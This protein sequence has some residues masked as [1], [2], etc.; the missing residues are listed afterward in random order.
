MALFARKGE[1]LLYLPPDA[2]RPNPD[3]PRASFA[4]QALQELADSIRVHGILQPL[5][6]RRETDGSYTL[7]AGERRLRA[8]KL[9]GLS[10]VPCLPV[11]FSQEDSALLALVENLQRCDLDCWEEAAALRRLIDNYGL[12]QEQAAQ[13]IG[14]SQ[15]AVANKLRLLKLSPEV[16]SLLRAHDLTER[17]ARALL[18]LPEERRLD[19]LHYIIRHDLNVAAADKYIDSL[20]LPPPAKQKKPTILLR[21]VR[22]FLNTVSRGVTAL[23]H[24]GL[25]AQWQ[26]EDTGDAICLTIRIPKGGRSHRS[27]G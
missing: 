11:D 20:L 12:S 22:L 23:K 19:A 7:V 21:D 9:A 8:A 15:S 5:S 4:P 24:S 26:Q 14:K 2:V 1:R 10:L 16:I 3:Q 18:R 25:D 6:V 27:A 17:H 13:K